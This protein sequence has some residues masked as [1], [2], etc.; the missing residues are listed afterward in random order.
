MR[1]KK[2][3]RTGLLVSEICFGTMTIGGDAG[4]WGLIGKLQQQDADALVKGAF[5]G[6][7]N[8]FD[9]ADVYGFGASEEIFGASIKGLGLPRDEIVVATKVHGRLLPRLGPD[10][11]PAQRAEAERR[12]GARN[13]NGLSRKHIM[14]AVD[15]SLRRLGLDY[16]DLYQ[17]HGLDPLTPMEETLGALD[18]VVKAGKVRYIGLCNQAAWQITKSLWI[19]DKKN[20]SRFESLQMYYSIAGR[21]LE[22]EVVPLAQDQELAILPWSP[23][24][25]GFLT[26]K[27]TRDGGPN[28]ARRTVFDFPPVDRERA[29]ACIDAMRPIAEAQKATIAGVAL[30]WLLHKPWVTS[31]IIG[32]KNPDQLRDNLAA[33]NIKLTAEELAALDSVSALAAEYPGWMLA[34]QGDDRAGQIS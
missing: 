22:R 32:A 21:D 33:T 1:Y 8:F 6:G 28:D 11:T 23:L 3:G 15:D 30:A 20:L 19:S 13:V 29:F 5:D 10:A 27:H 34:R 16:I 25:G 26:G 24:A 4:I 2:L 14:H 12:A 18:D 9:T 7:V 31:V 17:I